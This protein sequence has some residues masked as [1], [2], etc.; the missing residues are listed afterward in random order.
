MISVESRPPEPPM[1]TTT[2]P[3]PIRRLPG[4]SLQHQV[5]VVLRD[6]IRAGHYRPGDRLPSEDRL[7]DD[8][9]VS[10]VTLRHAMASLE[11]DGL[12][13]KRQ[14][15]G[16]FVATPRVDA[17][18]HAPHADLLAHL[19]SVGET[20]RVKLLDL[21]QGPAPADV[22]AFFGAPPDA[23]FH[24]AVRLRSARGVPMFHVVTWLPDALAAS[25]TARDWDTKSLVDLLAA[26]RIAL[27]SGEQV[28]G[29]VL[30]DPATAAALATPVGA[31]LLQ[32]VRLHRD[33]RARPVAH[34]AMLASPERFQVRLTLEP[35]QRP[36]APP[37]TPAPR[38]R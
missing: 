1:P 30:A 33:A 13:T 21:S 2:I 34:V 3:S 24:R 12:V 28:I 31:P 10:R 26:Q 27:S 6:A 38:R 35:P 23:L 20:T 25:L 5:F 32:V 4:A 17:A 19:R 36:P 29:A 22:R 16:T 14:G 11:A 9:G 8:F 18:I 37:A 15:A 7:A